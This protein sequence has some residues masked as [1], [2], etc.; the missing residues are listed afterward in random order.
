MGYPLA[1]PRGSPSFSVTIGSCPCQI[2]TD[3]PGYAGLASEF[4]LQRCRE[5]Q[6][7]LRGGGCLDD[8]AHAFLPEI[9]AELH[10]CVEDFLR[11]GVKF[12][13][14]CENPWCPL[15]RSL[16]G[17]VKGCPRLDS[18]RSPESAARAGHGSDIVLGIFCQDIFALRGKVGPSGREGSGPSNQLPHSDYLSKESREVPQSTGFFRG[19]FVW[20]KVHDV[21]PYVP[22][23]IQLLCKFGSFDIQVELAPV[24][25]VAQ[26]L[27]VSPKCE[28]GR[29]FHLASSFRRI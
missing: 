13:K 22:Y 27:M 6:Q 29:P 16:P 24:L 18:Q 11:E 20:I 21:V 3:V 9:N 17:S 2:L 10:Q 4:L 7:Q 1:R 19:E 15:A 12:W 28:I 8:L 23:S 26:K 5:R 14:D 25:S